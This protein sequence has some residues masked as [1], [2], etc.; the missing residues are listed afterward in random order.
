MNGP[1]RV[2]AIR[3]AIGTGILVVLAA[4]CIFDTREAN[5]PRSATPACPLFSGVH[6]DS[7]MQ[8]LV[9]AVGCGDQGLSTYQELFADDFSFGPDPSDS[10]EV[11]AEAGREETYLNWT[12][13]VETEVFSN[14][15]AD[16]DSMSLSLTEVSGTITP[17]EAELV[18]EYTLTGFDDGAGV[19]HTGE[20]HFFLRE[21]FSIW[22]I[23]RWEDVRSTTTSWG[24]LKADHRLGG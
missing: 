5:D 15:A 13:A 3:S 2:R 21:E 10:I 8:S 17:P 24:R 14:I 4:G 18:M 6:P 20:A 1:R 11:T 16:F 22:R 19:D 9:N 7:V 23:Y 12:D